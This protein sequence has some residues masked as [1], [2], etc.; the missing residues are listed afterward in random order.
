MKHMLS[1]HV[2][3]PHQLERGLC[4]ANPSGA[5]TTGDEPGVRRGPAARLDTSTESAAVS[6]ATGDQLSACVPLLWDS[7]SYQSGPPEPRCVRLARSDHRGNNI[8]LSL[9]RGTLLNF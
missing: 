1:V 4:W 7:W 3:E 8:S 6:G 9:L 5:F 2:P